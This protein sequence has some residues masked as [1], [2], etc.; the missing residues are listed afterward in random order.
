MKARYVYTYMLCLVIANSRGWLE[1]F[2]NKKTA[3][4]IQ[5][6]ALTLAIIAIIL[7][8][9][10]CRNFVRVFSTIIATITG[11]ASLSLLTTI[12][13]NDIAP[14]QTI[15]VFGVN[16][17]NL[18]FLVAAIALAYEL[19]ANKPTNYKTIE[20]TFN[21]IAIFVIL[22]GYLQMFGLI[23]LPGEAKFGAYKRLSGPHGSKQ[24]YSIALS[25]F[26]YLSFSLARKLQ[27]NF[28]WIIFSILCITLLIS[29]TRIGYVIFFISCAVPAIIYGLTNTSTGS[30]KAIYSFLVL[31]LFALTL[32]LAFQE[33]TSTFIERLSTFTISDNTKRIDSW[34]KGISAFENLRYHLVSDK[35]G[36]ASQIP[37]A[38]F[39]DRTPHYESAHLQYLV[40]F[41]IAF[42]LCVIALF[43]SWSIIQNSLWQLFFPIAILLSLTFYMSNEI[44]PCFIIFPLLSLINAIENP[45]RP[46]QNRSRVEQT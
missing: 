9:R 4:F 5:A 12:S 31:T 20:K 2:L 11:V 38:L 28:N 46:T 33:E 45:N 36:S 19:G 40:N 22:T 30:T 41:G 18:T 32:G 24:H 39:N 34:E 42:W 44:V 14:L 13:F 27:T 1:F 15:V 3:Y 25:I 16:C 21:A 37:S 23:D 29:F 10:N 43:L 35:L 7:N 8:F 17:L 6:M 26:T